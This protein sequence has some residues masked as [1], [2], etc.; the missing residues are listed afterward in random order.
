MLAQIRVGATRT[1]LNFVGKNLNATQL[2][3]IPDTD[4]LARN[5]FARGVL[6]HQ[7]CAAGDRKP[8]ARLLRQKR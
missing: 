3:K 2:R 6:H 7:V 5:Q 8:N 4:Q 1:N